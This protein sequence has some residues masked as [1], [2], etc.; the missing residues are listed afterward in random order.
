MKTEKSSPDEH[1]S[2]QL[3]DCSSAALSSFDEAWSCQ[4][5]QC[6]LCGKYLLAVAEYCGVLLSCVASV[7]TLHPRPTNL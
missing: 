6:T 3:Y 1:N 5:V 2:V 4:G 7:F